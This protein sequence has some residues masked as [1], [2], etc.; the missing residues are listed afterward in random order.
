MRLVAGLFYSSPW[1]LQA[2][3]SIPTVWVLVGFRI[4]HCEK[5]V[6]AHGT[7]K[8]K[9]TMAKDQHHV[10]EGN[11]KADE[12]AKGRRRCGWR[13]NGS[14]QGPNHQT[15]EERN[16]CFCRDCGTFSSAK[17]RD[18]IVPEGKV[19]W[20]FVERKEKAESTGQKI[21]MT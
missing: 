2:L 11:G 14:G 18:E 16:M 15:I 9:K 12:V 13:A 21:A 20:Q 10:M 7:E 17:D 19:L 3:P 6:M 8:G 4:T 5:R 1:R